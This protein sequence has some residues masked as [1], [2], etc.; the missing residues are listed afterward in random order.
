MKI[1][2]IGG[3]TRD[4]FIEHAITATKLHDISYLML[5]EGKKIDVSAIHYAT[6]GGATNSAVSFKRLGFEVESFFKVGIDH[7]AEIILQ[8]LASEGVTTHHA[9]QTNLANTGTSFMLPSPSGDRAILV[10]RGA[11]LLLAASDIPDGLLAGADQIY[12][13]SLGGNASELLPQIAA[14]AKKNNSV[15]A[16]NPG[17]S[18][19]TVRVDTLEKALG[20][21]DIL[22]L[23]SY[24][25]SLLWQSISEVQF[26]NEQ[27]F[28]TILERG[29]RI[30]VITNGAEGVSVCDGSKMY[31]HP[32]IPCKP[33]SSVGAGDAFGSTLVA[34]LALNKPIEEAIQAG[35]INAASVLMHL[36]AKAGLLSE[37]KIEQQRKNLNPSL[38]QV[39][40]AE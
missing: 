37:E 18:Q 14:Q 38:L 29:P 31:Y 34:Y 21:I 40:A 11:N 30:V 7:E 27:Y 19:L 2:T 12:I 3:A 24:E 15:V 6:G 20:Y 1:L 28:K 32:S 8:E 36:D 33:I 39:L 4:I 23:N 26:S 5:P 25:A 16:C 10:Y 9:Q 17:T 35:I 22:I 13:T